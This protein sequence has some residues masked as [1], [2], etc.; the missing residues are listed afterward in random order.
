MMP[1]LRLKRRLSL[2]FC[3]SI[4]PGVLSGHQWSVNLSSLARLFAE[5]A[6]LMSAYFFLYP[7]QG[8]S[9]IFRNFLAHDCG[10]VDGDSVF[11][12][13][14]SNLIV[15]KEEVGNLLRDLFG[16]NQPWHPSEP[17]P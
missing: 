11:G 17:P 13:V 10:A 15:L 8:L 6:C 1:A 3:R 2:S 9:L 4:E 5:S 14:H 12:L 7:I 16:A